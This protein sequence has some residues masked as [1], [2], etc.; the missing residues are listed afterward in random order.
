MIQ[1][2]YCYCQYKND[3]L[4]QFPA[5]PATFPTALIIKKHKISQATI[6]EPTGVPPR[7]DTKIPSDEHKTEITAEQIITLRNVLNIRIAESAGN[8]INAEIKSEPTKF[9]ASTMQKQ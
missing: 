5:P 3:C 7:T 1:A 2:K 9:I 8:I 4:F 6:V